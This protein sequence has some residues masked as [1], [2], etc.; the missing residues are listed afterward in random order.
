[1][2]FPMVALGEVV[3]PVERA[4]V[5]GAGTTYRQVGVKLWGVGAYERESMDGS[6]TRYKT[7]SRVEA[8]DIIVN[9]IWARNGSVAVVPKNLA[10]CFV[11]SEFPTFVPIR[12]KLEPRWFHWLTKTKSFWEK[13]DEK[14]QGTSGKNRIRPERFLEIEIPLPI[15]PE[16]RRIVARIEELATKIEEARGLRRKAGEEVKALFWA[17][18]A[19]IFNEEQEK[20]PVLPIGKS[21]IELNRETRNP[22]NVNPKVEFQYLDISSVEGG[23]GRILGTQKLFG[24]DAPSRARRVIRHFDVV[25]STV[26]PNLKSFTIVPSELDNQICSTGFAVFTCHSDIKP[27]F[28][29]YQMFSNYFVD[30]CI[31]S[32]KGGH[33]PAINEKNLRHVNL[34]IPPI[35]EQLRIV[36]YLDILQAKVDALRRLQAE[37][38]AEMDALM[39]A[40]LDRAFK[41]EL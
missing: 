37:I 19:K 35:A 36:T 26:R 38:G 6:Q 27:E 3:L 9:K 4:E 41:G 32:M 18:M 7:L 22:A 13:C 21:S 5:P 16:Q 39:P 20:W 15:I 33:Y 25:M 31:E 30:Q 17:E 29:L 12:E 14:S 40:V 10:G 2:S 1:M 11:S 8:D 24:S 23:T 28:L 34:I